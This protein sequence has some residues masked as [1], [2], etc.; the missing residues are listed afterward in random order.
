M[1]KLHDILATRRQHDSAGEKDII[2]RYIKPLNPVPMYQKTGEVA[3]YYI[4]IKHKDGTHSPIMWS[5]HTDTMHRGEPETIRQEVYV[6]SFGVMFVDE[7]AGCL[8]ADNGA[9]MWLLLEMIQAGVAGTYV[10]HRGEEI[11]CWGSRGVVE[12]YPE[13]L[14]EHTHAIA[15]DRKGTTSVI[16]HQMGGRAC[17]DVLGEELC[18][19]FGGDYVLDTTGV[20]TDTAEYVDIIPECVNVSIGYMN[21]HSSRESLDSAHCVALRDRIISTPWEVWKELSVVRDPSEERYEVGQTWGNG[22]GSTYM[23]L[24]PTVESALLWS[25][26]D[27]D[28]WAEYCDP[29]EA[30]WLVSDLLD[31][32][33]TLRGDME[34]RY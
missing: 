16:T 27:V 32:V 1:E 22:W 19:L 6:D 4:K 11:G 31:E 28:E 5:C 30:A 18:A 13:F 20:Y 25:D 33:R 26:V 12:N 34:F 2:N 8:G 9:G 7:G 10:F 14:A 15:F 23:N 29:V 3:A 24:A 17:S 21:E